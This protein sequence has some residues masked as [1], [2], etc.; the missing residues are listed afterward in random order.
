MGDKDLDMSHSKNYI[1]PEGI[2]SLKIWKEKKKKNEMEQEDEILHD[3]MNVLSFHEL[4]AES[5]QFLEE[6]SQAPINDELK[7]R[8]QFILREFKKRLSKEYGGFSGV[9]SDVLK[10]I[11]EKFS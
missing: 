5:N 8:G 2:L 6:L 7:Q 3:Y 10:S 11:E 9:L 1:E 4:I